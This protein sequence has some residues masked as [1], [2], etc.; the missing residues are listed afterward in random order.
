MT[1]NDVTAACIAYNQ[2]MATQPEHARDQPA[3]MRAALAAVAP[4]Y[5]VPGPYEIALQVGAALAASGNYATP[6]AAMVAAWAAV[7]E[8]YQGRDFY[9]TEIAPVMYP[10]Q[11]A[12]AGDLAGQD[13]PA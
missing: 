1:E 5:H 13:L 10:G 4:A 6:G 3:A 12:V 7:P 11:L 2:T 8:F 9:L